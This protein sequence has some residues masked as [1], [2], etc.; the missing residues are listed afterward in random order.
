[1]A[2]TSHLPQFEFSRL[3]AGKLGSAVLNMIQMHLRFDK[4]IY[5]TVQQ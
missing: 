5:S 1:M 3:V 2:S 4:G